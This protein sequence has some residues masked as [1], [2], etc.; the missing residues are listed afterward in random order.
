MLTL[1]KVSLTEGW[2]DVMNHGIDA[3]GPGLIKKR[4]F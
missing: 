1:F 4:D 2:I 3:R